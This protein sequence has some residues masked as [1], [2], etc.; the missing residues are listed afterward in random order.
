MVKALDNLILEAHAQQVLERVLRPYRV[1]GA[2]GSLKY[3]VG[4]HRHAPHHANPTTN[5]ARRLPAGCG[6]IRGP[7]A[8]LLPRPMASTVPATRTRRPAGR[9]WCRASP[10]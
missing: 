1:G 4:T 6:A 10:A 8:C 5:G 2:A 9:S 3:L 7:S